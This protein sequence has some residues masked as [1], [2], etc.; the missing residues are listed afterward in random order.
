MQLHYQPRIQQ[1]VFLLNSL[2][3]NLIAYKLL[4]FLQ[5]TFQSC[6]I[7]FWKGGS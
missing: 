5:E 4:H 1:I 6:H 2:Q 7:V 3:L